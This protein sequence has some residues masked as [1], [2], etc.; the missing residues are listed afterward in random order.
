MPTLE[1]I[2]RLTKDYA[3]ARQVLAER[4]A[5]LEDELTAAKRRRL[6]GIRGAKNRAAAAHDRLRAAVE[7]APELFRRPRTHI[8]HGVR[9]GWQKGR[10]ELRWDDPDQVVARIK[11]FMPDLYDTLVKTRVT[12]V[13]SALSRLSVAELRRI[14]VTVEDS[15]DQVLI[16]AT[17]SQLERMVDA[18][19]KDAI[20]QAEGEA[21]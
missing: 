18:L 11:R 1:D 7:S 20:E 3:E 2:E 8:F 21:A 9:V 13:K 15:G 6:A 17:D 19:L 4:V 5:A 14:G 16:K 10:G 12:P